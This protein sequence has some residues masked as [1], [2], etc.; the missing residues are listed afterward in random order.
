MNPLSC[1]S[2]AKRLPEPMMALATL[3]IKSSL[4][5]SWQ[6]CFMY[7]N[8]NR[9]PARPYRSSS[10]ISSLLLVRTSKDRYN[11]CNLS[12]SNAIEDYFTR[13]NYFFWNEEWKKK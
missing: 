9:Q 1:I 7:N 13:K 2:L 12:I 6:C 3:A 8:E 4:T 5:F 10:G 11:V